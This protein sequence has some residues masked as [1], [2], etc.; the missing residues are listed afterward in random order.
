MRDGLTTSYKSLTQK[1]CIFS[2]AL[3]HFLCMTNNRKKSVEL[4]NYIGALL[5]ER[6]SL[7]SQ[8]SALLSISAG[9]DSVCLLAIMAQ[10]QTQWQSRVGTVSCNH[11]WQEDSF[12]SLFHVSRVCLL[13]NQ[14]FYFVPV[15][16][17]DT[18][19][20]EGEARI[21][22]HN[23]VQRVAGFYQYRI[24]WT[25]HTGSDRIETLLFNLIRGSGK[26][27]LSSLYWSRFLT[28]CYPNMCYLS[29][30]DATFL[31]QRKRFLFLE[32]TGNLLPRKKRE[33]FRQICVISSSK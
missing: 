15:V 25:G 31:A 32:E 5:R 26:K 3:F 30:F 4:V 10:M 6:C 29:N 20:N 7:T 12:Y 17:T 27:G 2:F 8:I 9:Q 33:N 28:P 14:S 1:Q 19:N 23:I 13:L 11:L 24:I 22:R 21:W 16:L 18:G